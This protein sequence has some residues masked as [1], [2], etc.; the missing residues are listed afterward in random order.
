MRT[1]HRFP[2]LN[3]GAVAIEWRHIHDGAAHA[4][5]TAIVSG[6]YRPGDRLP[7]EIESAERMGI[8]RSVYREA[9]RMLTAKGMLTSKPKAGTIV[10]PR[11]SWHQLDP[12]VLAW[13]FQAGPSK[14]YIDDLFELRMAVEP[15]AA[16]LAAR[17]RTAGQLDVMARCLQTM[18][19]QTLAAEAG[20]AAD[21]LFHQTLLEATGNDVMISLSNGIAAA[22]RWATE[23]KQRHRTL[24]RDPVPDH[25]RLWEAIRCQDSEAARNAA[26]TLLLLAQEDTRQSMS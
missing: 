25:V 12:D 22:A 19:A 4:L 15:S 11:A 26:I 23:F 9:T 14:A 24:P 10:T 20:R 7:T 6:R 13:S 18:R 3:D 2:V 16:G 8:S 5:G 17:R 21:R 1:K